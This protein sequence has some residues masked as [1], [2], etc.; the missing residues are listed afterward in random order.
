VKTTLEI[1]DHIFRRAKSLAARRGIPLRVLVTEAV[2]EKL[3]ASDK[4][5]EKLW[6][7]LAG[8]L[9]HLHKETQQINQIINNEFERVDPTDW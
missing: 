5:D 7:K 6:L 9:R 2:V 8:G 3:K 1:P 4:Q